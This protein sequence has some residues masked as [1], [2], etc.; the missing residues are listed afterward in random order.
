[1]NKILYIAAI[2]L[3]VP[4]FFPACTQNDILYD[5]D[6][7]VT[8][9]AGNTY[10]AGEPVTFN[11][12][13]NVDNLLFYSGEPGSQYQYRDRYSVPVESLTSA[14]LELTVTCQYGNVPGGLD[15]YYSNTF[16]GLDGSDADADRAAI[17]SM[18]ENMEDAGWKKITVW[19]GDNPD[20]PSNSTATTANVTLDIYDSRE[21]FA[22]AFHWHPSE[23]AENNQAQRTYR[24]SGTLNVGTADGLSISS[25]LSDFVYTTFMTNDTFAENPYFVN[26]NPVSGNNNGAIRFDDSAY[27]IVFQGAAADIFDFNLDGWCFSIPQ[28]LNSV[29]NDKGIVIKNMQ[30]YLSSYYTYTYTEPGTYN[31]VFV[32]RNSNYIGTSEKIREVTVTILP[33]QLGSDSDE[34]AE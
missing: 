25:D 10:V 18:S 16:T 34:S 21:N 23:G 22:I 29:P 20:E 2:S 28:A 26:T 15:I 14:Q 8:L 24:I 13:G 3:A 5:A 12:S 32:G 31:A 9:D 17:S 4:V 33:P 27:D 1:M 30:N 19:G 7:N 11:F 6:Y